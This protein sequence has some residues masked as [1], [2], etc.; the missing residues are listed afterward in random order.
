[1]HLTAPFY[2]DSYMHV[3]MEIID[4][5][6]NAVMVFTGRSPQQILDEGG[7]QAWALSPRRARMCDYVVCVQNRHTHE[8]L[9]PTEPHNMAFMVGKITEVALSD[10]QP[11]PSEERPDRYIIKFREYA[12][13]AA[14]ATQLREG[15]RNPVSYVD[16]IDLGIDIKSLSFSGS[17]SKVAP[18]AASTVA[19]DRPLTMAQAKKGLSLTFGVSPDAIE[20]TIRG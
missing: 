13:I 11:D 1:M 3:V 12:R 15:N 10:E 9:N 2:T 7:T 14:D 5:P 6:K 18:A 19:E 8:S 16:L 17:S 4:V 20:I